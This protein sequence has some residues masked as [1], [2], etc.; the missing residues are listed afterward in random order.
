LAAVDG[1]PIAYADWIQPRSIAVLQILEQFV[2]GQ[3]PGA[4]VGARQI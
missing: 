4:L 3:I 2:Y 1:D